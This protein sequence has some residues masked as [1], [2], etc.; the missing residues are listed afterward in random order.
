MRIQ[1]SAKGYCASSCIYLLN[2][3]ARKWWPD[4]ERYFVSSWLFLLGYFYRNFI[5]KHYEQNQKT[6]FSAIHHPPPSVRRPSQEIF[7]WSKKVDPK[8]CFWHK[9]IFS[10]VRIKETQ[11]EPHMG[12][13]NG[14]SRYEGIKY[15]QK[16]S[17]LL[18]VFEI[19][20]K[21]LRK[22]IRPKESKLDPVWDSLQDGPASGDKDKT[23][24]DTY[25]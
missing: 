23:V 15:I 18:G 21:P 22:Y 19:K 8:V 2:E 25:S 3:L 17:I 20:K 16:S 9:K 10:L 13:P 4:L 6:L 24:L 1:N 12:S 7:L 5:W 14:W 11:R